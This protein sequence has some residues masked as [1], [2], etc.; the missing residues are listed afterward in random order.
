MKLRNDLKVCII[1]AGLTNIK[2][3]EGTGEYLDNPIHPQTITDYIKGR[4]T[5]G[6]DNA[7]VIAKV[8]KKPIEEIWWLEDD[9][10]E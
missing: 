2:L 9:P 10:G 6:L 8:L 1:R 4:K 5:P 3:A 7:L